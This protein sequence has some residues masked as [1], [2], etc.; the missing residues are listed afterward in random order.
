[1]QLL[2]ELVQGPT[3]S[4]RQQLLQQLT[5]DTYHGDGQGYFLPSAPEEFKLGESQLRLAVVVMDHRCRG[6][7]YSSMWQLSREAPGVVWCC[8]VLCC[9]ACCGSQPLSGA[10]AVLLLSC[11]GCCLALALQDVLS[12]QEAMA[13]CMQVRA[14]L[15][16]TA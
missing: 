8:A 7:S 10:L 13:E 6:V 5:P 1:V 2:E 14:L 15:A 16:K 9:A 3:Q 11:F 12:Q 4:R